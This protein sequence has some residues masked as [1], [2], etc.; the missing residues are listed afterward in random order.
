MLRDLRPA[1]GA[2]R[3]SRV[4]VLSQRRLHTAKHLTLQYELE[5]LLAG[6]DDVQVLSPDP[7]THEDASVATRYALNGGLRR[8]G[9]PRHSPPANRPSMRPTRVQGSHDLFFAVFSEAAELSYLRRLR[10]WRERSRYA[11]CLLLEVWSHAVPRDRDYYRLLSEFDAVYLFTPAAAPAL[12]ALGA[13]T[14]AFLPAGVDA[15]RTSPLPDPPPRTTDVYAYGRTSPVLHRQLLDLVRTSGLTYV[16]DTTLQAKVP[17][18]VDH[19][20][21][22]AEQMKRSVYTLAHRINDSPS[23]A[24]RTGG[25]E[26]LSTRY[27]EATAGGAVLLGSR[28]RTPDFAACFDWPDAVVDVPYDSPDLAAVLHELAGQPDRLAEARAHGVRAGLLRHDWVYRWEQVLRDARLAST[29]AMRARQD[30]LHERAAAVSSTALAGPQT[31]SRAAAP[32][33]RG[34][35]R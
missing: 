29:P 19:R 20:A 6:L 28:P 7:V 14:P 16:Y 25:E 23:R 5:D 8:A 34:P 10:G 24:R 22:L 1:D 21:L 15:E 3:D 31:V 30:R 26:S 12:A 2:D 32:W 33:G 13:P 11:V 9:L 4:L 18:H 17:D 35:A 27:F